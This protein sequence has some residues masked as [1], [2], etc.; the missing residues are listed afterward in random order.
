M[1]MVHVGHARGLGGNPNTPYMWLA[2]PAFGLFLP[3]PMWHMKR[4][5]AV[6]LIARRPPSVEYFSFTSFALW[7]P[8]RGLQFSSL[9]D[10]VNNLKLSSN[11]NLQQTEEGLFAHVLTASQTTYNLVEEALVK[12]GLP[13]TAINLL[14][15]PSDTWRHQSKSSDVGNLFD[16]WTH[17]ETVLRLFRFENQTEG[18]A[19][20]HSHYPVYYLRAPEVGE[21]F[22]SNVYKD[23]KHPDSPHE[24]GLQGDFK[25]HNQQLLKDVGEALES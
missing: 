22:A 14:K 11:K 8:R 16:D 12:S 1:R 17:F 13:K 19:Y 18:D 9:G 2:L 10:S 5:D 3:S 25:R 24:R 6:V 4:Q 7:V 15:M 23:R 21:L 20:L